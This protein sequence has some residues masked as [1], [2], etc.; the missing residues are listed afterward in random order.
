MKEYLIA[1]YDPQYRVN[2][3]YTRDEWCGKDIGKE[4][5][6]GV[7]TL[8]EYEST[9]RRYAMCATEILKHLGI[10]H[11]KLVRVEKHGK[12]RPPKE[13]TIVPTDK[14][15]AIIYDCLDEKYWCSIEAENAYIRT[16]YDLY[17]YIGCNLEIDEISAICERQKMF[18]VEVEPY[19]Y[20]DSDDE[21]GLPMRGIFLTAYIEMDRRSDLLDKLK[22]VPVI[23][24]IVLFYYLMKRSI[25]PGHMW[26]Y[27]KVILSSIAFS[28]VFV[29]FMKQIPWNVIR[30]IGYCINV[31]AV[32]LWMIFYV[33]KDIQK[34]IDLKMGSLS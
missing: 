20:D 28:L 8:E 19:V 13:N 4:F 24:T 21:P 14:V 30:M 34:I 22:F 23:H 15:G 6:D 10:D 17:M 31:Y 3:I 25:Y 29:L 16:D 33:R 32:I 27:L 2:G 1:K 7:L 18:A 12:I 9:L 5:A 11:T 26:C